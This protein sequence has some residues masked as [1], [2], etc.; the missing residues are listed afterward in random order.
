MCGQ[1]CLIER[2]AKAKQLADKG[3]NKSGNPAATDTRTFHTV[4]W[5]YLVEAQTLYDKMTQYTYPVPW[6]ELRRIMMT[7]TTYDEFKQILGDCLN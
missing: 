4:N 7:T 5:E 3:K 1:Q 2:Q 6:S